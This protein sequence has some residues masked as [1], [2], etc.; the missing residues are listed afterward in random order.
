MCVP[1]THPGRGIGKC[2]P[3]IYETETTELAGE[4]DEEKA[5]YVVQVLKL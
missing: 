2:C 4:R 5:K 1:L 3:Y